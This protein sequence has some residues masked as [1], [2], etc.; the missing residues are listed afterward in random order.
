MLVNTQNEYTWR[1]SLIGSMSKMALPGAPADE[2]GVYAADVNLRL[3]DRELHEA[4]G[5]SRHPRSRFGLT[6]LFFGCAI[7]ALCKQ[8]R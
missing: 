3:H 8:I 6:I 4:I 1:L 2:P 5:D 7:D